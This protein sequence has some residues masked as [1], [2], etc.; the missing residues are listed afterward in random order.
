MKPGLLLTL[1]VNQALPL[2]VFEACAIIAIINMV[3]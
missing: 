3:I 1:R 2:C